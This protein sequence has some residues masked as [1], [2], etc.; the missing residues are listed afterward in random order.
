[1]HPSNTIRR[2]TPLALAIQIACGVAL[3]ACSGAALAQA[4]APARQYD[5]PAGALGPALNQF[6]LQAGVSIVIEPA[7]VQGLRTQGLKG[8]YSVSEGFERLLR[9][10]GH[11]VAATDAGYVLVAAAPATDAP[12][13]LPAITAVGAADGPSE[14]SGLYTMPSMSTATRLGLSVRETPQSVSVVTRQQMDDQALITVPDILEKTV[15]VT[16]GRNDSERATFYA[17]GYVIENFQFDGMPNT[18]DSSNQYTSAIGDSAI[19]DRVEIVKGAGGLLTGAGNPSATI[20]LVRK[21]PGKEF[22]ASMAGSIGSWSKY[23]GTADISTPLNQDGSVRARVV[24]AAQ[25]ADSYIDYYSRDTR[26]AYAIIEADLAPRTVLSV[27]IDHMETR[28]NGATFGHLPLFYSDG[29]QTNFR[30]SLNPGARWSYWDN[31]S[32]NSFATLKHTFD[33]AWQLDL[34]ASHLDQSKDVMY[35]SAYNGSVNRTTGT[36]IRALAG[37]LPSEAKTD[38]ANL[39]LTGP[40]SLLGRTHELMLTAGYSR[41]HK[42]AELFGSVFVPV[43]NYFTWDGYLNQPTFTKRA[44]R[45]TK[46]TEQGVSIATRL[47][48][49]DQLSVILG[50]RASQYKLFDYDVSTGGVRSVSDDLDTGT[51][52]MPYAG[53][54]YDIN[55]NWSAY[56]SYTDIFN[57]QT[58]YKDANNRPLAPLTGK[59]A[60]IGVKAELLD[61][62]LNVSMAVFQIKQ[63]N[64]AQY[65]DVN[66]DTFE[67]IYKTVDGIKSDGFEAEVSG[68]ITPSW[69][70]AGGYTYRRSR[71]PK[72]QDV[73]L[74]AVNT[75][76]PKHLF[77]MS[78]SYRMNKLVVGGS[79]S[80][81]SDTYYQTSDDNMWRANQPGYALLGLMAR[82]EIDRHLS[83]ALNINN[84]LDKTYMPGLGSY[85]TGVYG[86]PRNALLTLKYQF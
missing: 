24:V 70:V 80:L 76:Q 40:F 72:Q 81:Q 28:A 3:P 35:G 20:N 8:G 61:K 71:V 26:N 15:G 65:V 49:T 37:L 51:K 19:Y 43:A 54:V 27:G 11:A 57:P 63:K 68:Q 39:A 64:A 69:N 83:V 31:D 17:R 47:R 9:G 2:L 14:N 10:T 4:A 41:Q 85:G 59:S 23:H 74:S 48:P 55:A 29:T 13:V 25:N 66:P 79:L 67:E 73:I 58:Y 50:A 1:M 21:R 32:T 44:D 5:I 52:T 38:S 42:Q 36:G 62:R 6:A 82:Y 53:V 86:D 16:V 30:R 84:A 56:A 22:S 46:I 34:M 45:D 7:R 78:T 75:N 60:E 12:Q 18:L 33:N 77:K